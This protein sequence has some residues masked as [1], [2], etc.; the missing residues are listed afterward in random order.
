MARSKPT[1]AA[2]AGSR[3]AR[4]PAEELSPEER[5]RT[6]EIVRNLRLSL[7]LASKAT[8]KRIQDAEKA[9]VSPGFDP[10]NALAMHRWTQT[11]AVILETHPGLER[12]LDGD[13]GMDGSRALGGED[14]TR[15]LRDA[16][17][18]RNPSGP[19]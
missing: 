4:V 7:E 10:E 19:A 16:L 18:G 6:V 14:A 13:A 8:L 12:F 1:G 11:I 9:G 5:K 15:E 3:K 2:A 17:R